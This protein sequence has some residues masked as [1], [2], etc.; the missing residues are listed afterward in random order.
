[1]VFFAVTGKVTTKIDV[2]AFGV[3]LME[4]ITGEKVLDDT[5]PDEDTNLVDVFRRNI[6]DK[7]KFLKS[8]P[9]PTLELDEEDLIS[10][11]E[12]AELARHC[13]ARELSQRPD[14]SHAV[15]K[16]ASL[17]E[18]WKPI[19]CEDDNDGDARMS[20]RGRLEEWQNGDS[21]FY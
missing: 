11:W 21:G 15:N 7:K 20:L 9:D 12:V 17:V 2:Y 10:L 3:I 4:L 14:M 18:R 19:R 6:V 8:S 5:R 1:M 13:T 16:L